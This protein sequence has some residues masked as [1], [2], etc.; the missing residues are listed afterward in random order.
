[1]PANSPMADQAPPGWAEKVMH[2][3]LTIGDTLITGW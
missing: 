2:A 1:L 3:S